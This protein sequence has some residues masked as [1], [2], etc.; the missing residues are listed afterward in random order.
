MTSA[1]IFSTF[2][3]LSSPFIADGMRQLELPPCIFE[4]AVHPLVPERQGASTAA[5]R[6]IHEE[7][8]AIFARRNADEKQLKGMGLK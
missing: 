7:E 2:P 1:K 8:E 4:P 6:E 3:E 5:A